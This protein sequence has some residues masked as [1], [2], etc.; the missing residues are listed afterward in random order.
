MQ[1]EVNQ[2]NVKIKTN[3]ELVLKMIEKVEKMEQWNGK[4]F[5]IL[6]YIFDSKMINIEILRRSKEK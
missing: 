6:P 2:I 5:R 1:I 4:F 3:A